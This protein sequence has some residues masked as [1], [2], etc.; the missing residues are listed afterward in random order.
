MPVVCGPTTG[1]SRWKRGEKKIRFFMAASGGREQDTPILSPRKSSPRRRR[2]NIY[3]YT[4]YDVYICTANGKSEEISETRVL[5]PHAVKHHTSYTQV[6]RTYPRTDICFHFCFPQKKKN[7]KCVYTSCPTPLRHRF[8]HA[9]KNTCKT[10][11]YIP[12]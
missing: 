3:I 10:R 1:G 6:R 2:N 5:V 9:H 12:F 4:R 7:F 11:T 8:E